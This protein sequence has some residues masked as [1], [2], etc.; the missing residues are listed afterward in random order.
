MV[1]NTTWRVSETR[2]KDTAYGWR[3]MKYDGVMN[4]QVNGMLDGA[5]AA[6]LRMEQKNVRFNVPS[7]RRR[8]TVRRELALMGKVASDKPARV[9]RIKGQTRAVKPSTSG[10]LQTSKA[11]QSDRRPQTVRIGVS[12]PEPETFNLQSQAPE[13][14]DRQSQALDFDYLDDLTDEQFQELLK[15]NPEIKD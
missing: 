5:S 2:I 11:E 15:T 14:S 3:R 7:A 6:I 9:P 13:S 8:S 10:T 12:G 1:R 4:W